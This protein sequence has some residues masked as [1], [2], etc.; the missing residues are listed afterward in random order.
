MVEAIKSML[1]AQ[2]EDQ[3]VHEETHKT[4]MANCK[5]EDEFRAAEVEEAI[6]AFERSKEH[7]GLCQTRIDEIINTFPTLEATNKEYVEEFERATKQRDEEHAEFLKK[8][9]SF[10]QAIEVFEDF[11]PYVENQFKGKFFAYSFIQ[12][13]EI[14]LKYSI[15]LNRMSHAIPVLA[16]IANI[17]LF[18]H[19]EF[20]HNSIENATSKLKFAS[21]ISKICL[22]RIAKPTKTKREPLKKNSTTTRLNSTLSLPTLPKTSNAPNN[23]NST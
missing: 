20:R 12:V 18:S 17:D 22:T 23:T 19:N 2:K 7:Y 9:V 15:K 6:G 4:M 13:S 3:R 21:T 16:Q 10:T 5:E 14:I 11:I 8:Q 1:H